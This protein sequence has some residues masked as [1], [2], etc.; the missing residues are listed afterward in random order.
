VKF[1]GVKTLEILVFALP[2]LKFKTVEV[3][4]MEV[5]V[6]LKY[7]LNITYILFKQVS[8]RRSQYI[9]FLLEELFTIRK[10]G[11]S[12]VFPNVVVVVKENVLPKYVCLPFISKILLSGALVLGWVDI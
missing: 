7:C 8:L 11:S 1:P 5:I 2:G 10:D 4:P 9:A 3:V 12:V 6:G